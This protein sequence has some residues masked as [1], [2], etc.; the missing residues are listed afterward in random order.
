[1]SVGETIKQLRKEKGLTQKELASK[2]GVAEVTIRQYETSK[3]KPKF[4]NAEKLAAFFEANHLAFLFDGFHGELREEEIAEI[5]AFN[6]IDRAELANVKLLLKTLGFKIKKTD[7]EFYQISNMFDN[8]VIY[9]DIYD[10][11]DLEYSATGYIYKQL[12]AIASENKKPNK[13]I[14]KTKEIFLQED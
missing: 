9:A 3:R 7:E 6:S 13:A 1:M 5:I 8:T 4:E 2:I 10:I 11:S 12:K 14:K